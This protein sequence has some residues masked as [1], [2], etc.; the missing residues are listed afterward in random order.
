M[1]VPFQLAWIRASELSGGR[2]AQICRSRSGRLTCERDLSRP[3]RCQ[4][5]QPSHSWEGWRFCK[6]LISTALGGFGEVGRVFAPSD[7][8]ARAC[9]R[10]RV[11]V[12]YKN[13]PN[14]PNPPICFFFPFV[15]GH[16]R[17]SVAFAAT[18]PTLPTLPFWNSDFSAVANPKI[19][20][21]GVRVSQTEAHRACPRWRSTKFLVSRRSAFRS[22]I[23][24]SSHF[25]EDGRFGK[26]LIALASG[27]CGWNGSLFAPSDSRVRVCVRARESSLQ[28]SSRSSHPPILDHLAPYYLPFAMSLAHFTILPFFPFFQL[29]SRFRFL[30]RA[31][32]RGFVAPHAKGTPSAGRRAIFE[33][34]IFVRL[35]GNSPQAAHGKCGSDPLEPRLSAPP[36]RHHFPTWS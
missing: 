11:A 28:I 20:H 34:T 1:I 22:P 8:Y 2:F 36:V 14:P 32:P 27:A 6:S 9:A 19:S 5:S 13:P 4:L 12:I 3:R 15:Y 35:W 25:R 17:S 10:A 31:V 24:P 30:R 26:L 23:L 7:S 21:R 18:L 16:F 33:Q 29:S